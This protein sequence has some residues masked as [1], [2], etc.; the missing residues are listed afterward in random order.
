M[1][2]KDPDLDN[3]TSSDQEKPPLGE[4]PI[5]LPGEAAL[6][7]FAR[8]FEASARRWELIVYPSLFAFIVLAAYGFYLI[9]SLTRD[10]HTMARS[11]D[12]NMHP[13]ME[14]MAYN[15]AQL[16]TNIASMTDRID[17]MAANVHNMDTTVSR[18]SSYIQ[19]MKTDM[20]DMADKMDALEPMRLSMSVMEESI[21]SMNRSISMMNQSMQV[22]TANTG[23]MTLNTGVMSRDMS[24]MNYNFGRPMSFINSFMPW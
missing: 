1:G 3:H 21:T 11:I 20:S 22:M 24:Y 5:P 23:A 7:R 16:S 14:I 9:Y 17:A 19:V 6:D 10:M 2:G 4:K 15:I 8:S 12:P 18:M 13:H